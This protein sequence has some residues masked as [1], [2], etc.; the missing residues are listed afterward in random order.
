MIVCLTLSLGVL[1]FTAEASSENASIK[2]TSGAHH[3]HVLSYTLPKDCKNTDPIRKISVVYE[4]SASTVG[5]RSIYATMNN[6][7]ISKNKQ[8]DPQ[9]FQIGRAHV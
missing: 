8:V 7:R 2:I 1:P 5:V 4:T 6:R 3:V 9:T